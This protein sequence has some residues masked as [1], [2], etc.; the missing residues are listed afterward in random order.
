MTTILL[1]WQKV[2]DGNRSA[3]VHG[4][5][6]GAVMLGRREVALA[7]LAKAKMTMATPVLV[8]IQSGRPLVADESAIEAR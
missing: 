3:H 4:D 2:C 8:A 1:R 7:R 6:K 5:Q